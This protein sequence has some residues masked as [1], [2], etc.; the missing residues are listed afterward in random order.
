MHLTGEANNLL[1]KEWGEI[2]FTTVSTYEVKKE[3]NI[4]I[5]VQGKLSK[6][7]L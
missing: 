4:L 2:N 6:S 1:C 3:E 5:Y 7:N